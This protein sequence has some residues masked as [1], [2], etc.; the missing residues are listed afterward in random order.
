M[1]GELNRRVTIKSWT[2]TQ[3]AGGGSTAVE[4][5]SYS[6][7]AKVEDRS[8]AKNNGQG[9]TVWNYD[10]RITVRY[11]TSRVILSNM[12]VD[13][14]GKRLAINEVSFDSE[15]SK[16]FVVLRCTTITK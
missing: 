11:E 5:G 7:W 9:Q 6:L 3:D 4:S 16:R 14:D 13:Y 1:I 8:G 2:T 12:T 15:G 10:Y